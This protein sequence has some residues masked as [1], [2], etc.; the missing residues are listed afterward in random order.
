M[1][2]RPQKDPCKKSDIIDCCPASRVAFQTPG[3]LMVRLLFHVVGINHNVAA[4]CRNR[5]ARPCGRVLHHFLYCVNNVGCM[6][7]GEGGKGTEACMHSSQARS[8]TGERSGCRGAGRQTPPLSFLSFLHRL[9]QRL[10]RIYIISVRH[11][12]QSV[13]TAALGGAKFDPGK[14][15]SRHMLL[16]VPSERLMGLIHNFS[17]T[18][19]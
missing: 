15:S 10:W 12:V 17:G 2:R 11:R 16:F 13:Y 6:W 8:Y 3:I 9:R 5:G 19:L 7:G 1:P 4:P 18:E 14:H